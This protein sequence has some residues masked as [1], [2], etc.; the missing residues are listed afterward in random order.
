[1]NNFY[2]KQFK[3]NKSRELL[4]KINNGNTLNYSAFIPILR[5]TT[6]LVNFQGSFAPCFLAKAHQQVLQT[7]TGGKASETAPLPDAL[8]LIAPV[9]ESMSALPH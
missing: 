5:K 2:A 8:V 6:I 7:K 4:K 3:L 9:V 1:M